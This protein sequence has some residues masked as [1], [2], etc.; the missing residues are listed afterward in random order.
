MAAPLGGA[1]VDPGVPTINAKK[2]VDS[3]PPGRRCQRSDGDLGA[4]IINA[5]K[6]STSTPGGSDGD[7]GASTIN[8]KKHRSWAPWPPWG[9]GSSLHPGSER[10]IVSLHGQHRLKKLYSQISFSLLLVLLCL[11]ILGRIMG[12]R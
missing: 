4:P 2:N 10:C 5:K 6:M 3:A 12:H 7:P 9:G 1:D 11:T 8:A